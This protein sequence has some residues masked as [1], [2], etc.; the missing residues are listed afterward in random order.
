VE[1]SGD[2][3]S[4]DDDIGTGRRPGA[5][6]RTV[7]GR[8]LHLPIDPGN[9]PRPEIAPSRP[10]PP[11]V[12]P[13]PVRGRHAAEDSEDLEALMAAARPA[14]PGRSLLAAA[15][16]LAL[17]IVAGALVLRPSRPAPG[18]ALAAVAPLPPAVM[19]VVPPVLPAPRPAAVETRPA[20]Q[21]PAARRAAR[22]ARVS[23]P[24]PAAP[25]APSP[26]PLDL[27]APLPP[28]F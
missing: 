12:D 23:I 7:F 21:P 8:D 1:Y 16:V 11:P 28:S 18:P 6:A 2:R 22:K 17:A 15:V 19:P 24:R 26:M 25:R 3:P 10:F 27:D 5:G 9:L 4:G 13:T 14:L 20:A